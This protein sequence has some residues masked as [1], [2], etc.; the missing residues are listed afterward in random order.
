M[1]RSLSIRDVV[2]ID[3]LDLEVLPGLSILS[4]ET[5]A[6]KSILLEVQTRERLRQ[7]GPQSVAQINGL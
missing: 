1:L 2:L 7:A 6:G 5:G 3:R 4:G